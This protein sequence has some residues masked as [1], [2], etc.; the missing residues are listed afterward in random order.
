MPAAEAL[1]FRDVDA[2]SE[3]VA[4]A[5]SIGPGEASRIYKTTDGG[6]RWELQFANT[7]PKVFLDAMAF[8]DANR[9]VAF[10][11]SVDGRFVILT[12][13]D[14]GRA[15]NRVPADRLP[16]ALPGEGAFAASGTNVA[17]HGREAVW[18]GTTAGRVLRSTDDGRSW[19]IAATPIR[20]NPSAGIFSIAFRDARHGVVV[21]GDYSKEGEAVDNAAFTSDGGVTWTLVKARGLSG[22]RS[23]VAWVPG[24]SALADCRRALRR[25]LVVRRRTE[26]DAGGRRRFRHGELRGADA[27]RLCRGLAWTDCTADGPVRR[28]PVDQPARR[29]FAAH[30]HHRPRLQRGGDGGGGRRQA[31]RDRPARPP[32]NHRRQRRI[33][34]RHAGRA[35]RARRDAA[36]SRSFMPI[37]NRGK[38][39]AIRLGFARARGTV[40][41]IQDADLELDPAQLAFLVDPIVRGS[42]SVVYGSRFLAGRPPA[43]WLSIVANRALTWLTNAVYGSS[44]TDMETCYKIMRADV[45]RSLELTSDRFDIEPEI[46]ARLLVAGHTIDERPVTFTPRSRAAGKKIGWRDGLVAVQVLFRL[47]PR[48]AFLTRALLLL[49]LA[50]VLAAFGLVVSGGVAFRIAGVL[51]RAHNPAVAIGVALGAGALLAARGRAQIEAASHLVVESARSRR[52]AVG[53][54]GRDRGDRDGLGVGHARR[55]RIGFVLLSQRGGAARRRPG[56][57]A[58]A[59]CREHSVARQSMGVRARGPCAGSRSGRRDRADLP[60]RATRF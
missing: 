41:A 20:T 32:R 36:A 27:H 30:L 35:R 38:G 14:G 19:A 22:F 60:C 11:D 46:T 37:A 4:Y 2:L 9:G 34:R 8:R 39:H 16:A 57:A 55:G 10:S 28:S 51:V 6:A 18:I 45:A 13:A 53:V 25:R 29:S 50:T 31:A 58:A 43:P 33:D 21:G 15:W 48:G 17:L 5:L 7:D 52:R 42:S 59:R 1:D 26:L 3:H 23:V 56:A 54:R 24:T 40:V 12:T 47:R 49:A 44:L